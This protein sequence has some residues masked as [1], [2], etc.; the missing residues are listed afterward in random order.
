MNT[1]HLHV[2]YRK[3]WLKVTEADGHVLR[4]PVPPD[5]QASNAT[6]ALTAA[7]RPILAF[8]EH[9]DDVYLV[10]TFGERLLASQRRKRDYLFQLIHVANWYQF[11]QTGSD[12]E[13]DR[14]EAA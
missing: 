2:G 1:I 12:T 7:L 10:Q 3:Q 8:F 11:I 14:M 4:F 6:D 5:T 13:S 9:H